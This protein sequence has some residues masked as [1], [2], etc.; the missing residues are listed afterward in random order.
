M[1]STR[2]S[3]VESGKDE[4]TR[5]NGFSDGTQESSSFQRPVFST[6][7]TLVMQLDTGVEAYGIAAYTRILKMAPE[8]AARVIHD[9][10]EI[11]K[12]PSVHW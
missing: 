3:N 5:R 6:K 1:D 11:A 2:F 12:D 10:K 7:T 4:K 8:E 9:A